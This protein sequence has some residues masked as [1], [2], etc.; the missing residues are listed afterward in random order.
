MSEERRSIRREIYVLFALTPL[1]VFFAWFFPW[2][3]SIYDRY[4]LP[5]LDHY[6][7]QTTEDK[8]SLLDQWVSHH[9]VTEIDIDLF[10]RGYFD[11]ALILITHDKGNSYL[12]VDYLGQDKNSDIVSHNRTTIG[13]LWSK[14][15]YKP[16]NWEVDPADNS[17]I[18]YYCPDW[19]GTTLFLVLAIAIGG[20]IYTAGSKILKDK[21][22]ELMKAEEEEEEEEE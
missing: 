21:Y 13:P 9:V 12:N 10:V 14:R 11:K 22:I 15:V 20:G 5:Y 18:V 16:Y 4:D 17:L 19:L 8:A 6:W 1:V 7:N 3:T 2:Q